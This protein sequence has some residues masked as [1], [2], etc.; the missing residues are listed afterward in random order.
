MKLYSKR[1]IT[2]QV[3]TGEV[4]WGLF[5]SPLFFKLYSPILRDNNARMKEDELVWGAKVL[6][7]IHN[8]VKKKP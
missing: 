7:I 6:V 8:P 3:S 5:F 2:R 1:H 4:W